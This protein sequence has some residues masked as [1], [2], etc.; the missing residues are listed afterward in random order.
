MDIIDISGDKSEKE[1]SA[2]K[3]KGE[4]KRL[5]TSMT[6]KRSVPETKEPV[7]KALSRKV[8]KAANPRAI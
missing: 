8:A 1:R 3:K 7:R 2:N 6:L 5:A 4:S